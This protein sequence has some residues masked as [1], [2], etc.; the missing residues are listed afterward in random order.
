MSTPMVPGAA[1]PGASMV[2][3]TR[4]YGPVLDEPKINKL[5]DAVT[6]GVGGPV[7]LTAM[8]Q[9]SRLSAG[10]TAGLRREIDASLQVGDPRRL[11][12]LHIAAG[13]GVN[14]RAEVDVLAAEAVV[15]VEAADSAWAIGRAEQIR[16]M[17]LHAKGMP[18]P[19][20]C[21]EKGSTVVGVAVAVLTGLALLLGPLTVSVSGGVGGVALVVVGGAGGYMAGRHRAA[22]NRTVIWIDGTLPRSGWAAW[23][24]S[25]RIAFAALVG[26]LLGLIATVLTT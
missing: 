5:I 19:K 24:T 8:W 17:L 3:G 7:R 14:R 13:D 2:V 26:G 22:R 15:A 10:S 16:R 11:D 4:I 18:Q 21:L 25:D 12:S 20:R 23:S 1:T 9:G 6:D